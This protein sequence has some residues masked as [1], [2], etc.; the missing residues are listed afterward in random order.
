MTNNKSLDLSSYFSDLP[1]E[2]N[3]SINSKKRLIKTFYVKSIHRNIKPKRPFYRHKEFIHTRNSSSSSSSSSSN[4]ELLWVNQK[5]NN[6]LDRQR[7]IEA[8]VRRTILNR[9]RL[10]PL[11]LSQ[12]LN[13][14]DTCNLP[15]PSLGVRLRMISND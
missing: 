3:H 5:W 10:N 4:Q 9:D 11:E 15:L 12:W 6:L 13:S 2:S 7:Q 8:N 1:N 14:D